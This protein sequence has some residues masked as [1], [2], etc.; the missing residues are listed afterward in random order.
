MQDADLSAWI[1]RR[2]TTTDHLTEERAAFLTALLDRDAPPS[3]GEAVMPSWSFMLFAPPVRRRDAGRDGHPSDSVLNLPAGADRRMWAKSQIRVTEP[4]RV[5]ERLTRETTVADITRKDGRSGALLF[6]TLDHEI[7]GDRGA[8]LEDRQTILYRDAVPP[9]KPPEAPEDP[10]FAPDW[11]HEV[12]PDELMLFNY[13]AVS[14]NPHRIHYDQP[15]AT[16]VEGYPG[17][18][19]HGPLIGT[20]LLEWLERECPGRAVA[21]VTVTARRPLFLPE[22]FT[23]RGRVEGDAFRVAAQ[24]RH[25][26]INMTAEGRFV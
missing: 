26:A 10:G 16:G 5:G 3:A 13:S 6:V 12:A 8:R 23:V 4:I 20:W 15:Y 21:G 11:S 18:V 7:T 9:P 1:G 24:D 19:I 22:G 2:L 14:R 17:L 25:G